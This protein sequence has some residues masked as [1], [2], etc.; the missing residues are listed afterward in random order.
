MPAAVIKKEKFFCCKIYELNIFCLS[1][2]Q[3][4]GKA[5]HHRLVTFT[6]P[7]FRAILENL[8]GRVNAFI[9]TSSRFFI[10]RQDCVGLCGGFIAK[11]VNP[12]LLTTG[13]LAVMTGPG[14]GGPAAGGLPSSK[15]SPLPN[16]TPSFCPPPIPY[17][18]F[19]SY[20][21]FFTLYNHLVRADLSV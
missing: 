8:T 19:F 14:E 7:G 4:T 18:P 6:L 10:A 9:G 5:I 13:W 1:L 12:M 11:D 20:H 17:L 21:D 15:N 2:N 3:A 16:S